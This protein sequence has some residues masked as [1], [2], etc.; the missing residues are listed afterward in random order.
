MDVFDYSPA[1]KDIEYFL[2]HELADHYLEMIKGS[3]YSKENVESIQYTLYTVGLGIVKLFAPFFPHITEEIYHDFYKS[4]EGDNSIHLSAWPQA[5]LIDDE[6]EQAGETVKEYIA[7]VRAWKSEQGI[8]LNAPIPAIAT[9]AP[10]ESIIR[11]KGNGTIIFST[12]RYPATHTFIPGK[13]EIQETITTVEPVFSKLGP[14]FKNE[15]STIVQWI[16]THQEELIAKIE[17]GKDVLI[18]E[19]PGIKTKTK[20]ALHK[21]G[22][23]Q[24]KREVGLKGKKGSTIVS[25]DGFYVELE[26]KKP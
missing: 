12:L 23:L 20:E 15:S 25:F 8:A 24:L 22:Y 17:N 7:K 14:T 26:R 18:S 3:L 1:M 9:Y 4:Y 2:W 21:S 5:T 6:K 13:P 11:L 10:S 16:K 19:I